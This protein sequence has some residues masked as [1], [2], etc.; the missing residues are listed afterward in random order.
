MEISALQEKEIDSMDETQF[1]KTVEKCT[2]FSRVSP[3]HKMKII[4][5]LQSNGHIVAMTGDGVNDAPALKMADIGCAMGK[6]GTEVAK[7][8]SDMILTMIT[9]QQLLLQLKK[10][11]KYME[12]SKKLYI[13]YY[14]VTLVNF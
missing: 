3:E 2:V 5:A 14:Q 13:S 10:V 9:L 6:G 4:K 11:E 1:A 8:A 7:G 12:I